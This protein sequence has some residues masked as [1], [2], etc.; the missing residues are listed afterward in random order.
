MP[1]QQF[2]RPIPNW[3]HC[4][5]LYWSLRLTRVWSPKKLANTD[6]ATNSCSNAYLGSYAIDRTV[7]W[8]SWLRNCDETSLARV[9]KG[10]S[11][12]SRE[13]RA[14]KES[15]RLNRRSETSWLASASARTGKATSDKKWKLRRSE[16][17]QRND[18]PNAQCGA[19]TSNESATRPSY[20]NLV[21]LIIVIVTTGIW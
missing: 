13:L 9:T 20:S 18:W 17:N 3:T 12:I 5:K 2:Q 21:P 8:H 11:R 15:E 1:R 19:K 10:L 6:S 7:F 14:C 16:A 4:T